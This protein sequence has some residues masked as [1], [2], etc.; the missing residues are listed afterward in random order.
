MLNGC[1]VTC[2]SSGCFVRVLLVRAFLS[3][4]F[5]SRFDR[6]YVGRVFC[7]SRFSPVCLLSALC[8]VALSFSAVFVFVV[9]SGFQKMAKL[10]GDYRWDV[11]PF[12]KSSGH[13]TTCFGSQIH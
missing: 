13:F 2:L 12:A 8:C 7:C 6:C 1:F 9:F 4:L 10:I 3:A 11:L 5:C